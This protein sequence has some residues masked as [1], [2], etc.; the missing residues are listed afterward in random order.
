M[1]S[2]EDNAL[3]PMRRTEQAPR[4][5]RGLLGRA[6]MTV[7]LAG[8][9][10]TALSWALNVTNA[11]ARQVSSNLTDIQDHMERAPAGTVPPR[12]S[13]G[14]GKPNTAVVPTDNSGPILEPANS[15]K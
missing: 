3:K 4:V 8:M 5:D 11:N 7:V 1:H 6:I 2:T 14:S 12:P 10:I 13:Q 9:L 15:G